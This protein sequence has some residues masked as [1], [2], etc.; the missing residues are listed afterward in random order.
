MKQTGR[1][2]ELNGGE[3]KLVVTK[4]GDVAVVNNFTDMD[5]AVEVQARFLDGIAALSKAAVLVA[6]VSAPTR[7]LGQHDIVV[8]GITKH[9]VGRPGAVSI[10]C[11]T[12]SAADVATV[13]AVSMSMRGL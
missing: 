11:Q 3:L 8:H 4:A 7:T 5:G 2:I 13:H 9:V 6:A 12:I 10:G 1:K